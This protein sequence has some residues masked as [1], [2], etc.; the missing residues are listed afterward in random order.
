VTQPVAVI[1]QGREVTEADAQEFLGAKKRRGEPVFV[2]VNRRGR[3]TATI[4]SA[5]AFTDIRAKLREVPA[6]ARAS[7]ALDRLHHDVVKLIAFPMPDEVLQVETGEIGLA[8]REGLKVMI[9]G[10]EVIA[11]LTRQKNAQRIGRQHVAAEIVALAFARKG[12]R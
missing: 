8:W 3:A 4:G 6:F 11:I 2:Q 5:D 12:A 10:D 7:E 9:G 1:V